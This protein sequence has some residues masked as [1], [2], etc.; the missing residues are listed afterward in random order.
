MRVMAHSLG[1]DP[2][3]LLSAHR[4]MGSM[5]KTQ[6]SLLSL[7]GGLLL[8]KLLVIQDSWWV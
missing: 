1:L 6:H 5:Y 2:E 3:V 4:L 7:W 8:F